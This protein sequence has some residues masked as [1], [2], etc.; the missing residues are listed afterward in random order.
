[1]L[2]TSENVLNVVTVLVL[3]EYYLL[4]LNLTN[5][6]TEPCKFFEKKVSF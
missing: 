6:L 4:K 5:E 2:Q 1:M 3:L